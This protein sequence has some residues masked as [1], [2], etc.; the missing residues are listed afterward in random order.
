M[1]SFYKVDD[2]FE[3]FGINSQE[4][5]NR[6]FL[7]EGY[8]HNKVTQ[9]I[10]EAFITVSYL[11]AFTYFYYPLY[12]EAFNKALRVIEIAIK[13]KCNQ[14]EIATN[15][16]KGNKKNL[17]S[18]IKEICNLEEF[19]NFS[20]LLDRFRQLRNIHMHPNEHSYMGVVGNQS[21]NIKL[22]VNT[23]N[24]LFQ[25]EDWHNQQ[26]LTKKLVEEKIKEF[27]K[28]PFAIGVGKPLFAKILKFE[29][30]ENQIFFLLE[31]V[32]INIKECLAKHEALALY[33][34][35]LL[36]FKIIPNGFEGLDKDG[37]LL[38]LTQSNHPTNIQSFEAYQLELQQIDETELHLFQGR[39]NDFWPI[40]DWEYEINKK[41]Y[42]SLVQ[43]NQIN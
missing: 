28:L 3:I 32:A 10:K 26:N 42:P 14:L 29:T 22:V 43:K 23:I 8:F 2:R 19:S 24:Q 27:L 34:L 15:T 21:S 18:L 31:R 13:Q 36:D 5:F 30:F 16:E 20:H 39:L 37:Q 9:N 41:A 33:P 35:Q 4:E 25:N 38:S 6:S 40:V 7:I 12:D 17:D 1:E 11:T